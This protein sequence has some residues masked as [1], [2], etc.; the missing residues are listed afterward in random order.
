MYAEVCWRAEYRFS[1]DLSTTSLGGGVSPKGSDARA[2]LLTVPE[3]A[4]II[5]LCVCVRACVSWQPVFLRGRLEG[6]C[7]YSRPLTLSSNEVMAVHY[8]SSHKHTTTS[9][10]ARTPYFSLSLSRSI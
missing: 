8:T 1:H 6:V 7:Q 3:T 2:A 9:P 5:Q 4:Q 10:S